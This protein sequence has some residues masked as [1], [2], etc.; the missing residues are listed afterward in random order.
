MRFL[1]DVNVPN[2]ALKNQKPSSIKN[3]KNDFFI[4]KHGY[5]MDEQTLLRNLLRLKN[6]RNNVLED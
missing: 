2:N 5:G 1:I 4:S 6:M 3:D